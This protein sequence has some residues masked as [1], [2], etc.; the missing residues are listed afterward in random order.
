V[1]YQPASQ[2]ASQSAPALSHMLRRAAPSLVRP[3]ARP[4][5]PPPPHL[6]LLASPRQQHRRTIANNAVAPQIGYQNNQLDLSGEIR[7][8]QQER[9]QQQ[10]GT[11]GGGKPPGGDGGSAAW[12]SA[13]ATGGGAFLLSMLCA[14]ARPSPQLLVLCRSP[15]TYLLQASSSSPQPASSTTTGPSIAHGCFFDPCAGAILG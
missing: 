12:Q 9:Q 13:I 15:R 14:R 11:G 1:L 4:P 7:D 5:R 10:G 3:L 2:T 8:E 6:V